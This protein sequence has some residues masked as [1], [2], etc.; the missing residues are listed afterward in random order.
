MTMRRTDGCVPPEQRLLVEHGGVAVVRRLDAPCLA[1]R[2]FGFGFVARTASASAGED[3][4]SACLC[5]CFG[6]GHGEEDGE[7]DVEEEREWQ[8]ALGCHRA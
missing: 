4:L 7:D 3:G 6:G 5:A 1:Y 2:D 8:A